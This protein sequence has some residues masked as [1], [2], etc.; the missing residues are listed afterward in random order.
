VLYDFG[1]V[2]YFPE[3]FVTAYS[4]LVRETL[5]G[6][7]DRLPENLERIGLVPISGRSYGGEFYAKFAV[8]LLEPFRGAGPYDFGEARIHDHIIEIGLEHWQDTLQFRAPPE[9]VF[10]DRVVAGM[11]NNLRKLRARGD[12]RSILEAH[13]RGSHDTAAPHEKGQADQAEQGDQ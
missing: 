8:P 1:C 7:Y 12:W 11:Y 13:L 9:I 2:R 10:L 3:E 6:R 5:D 4:R